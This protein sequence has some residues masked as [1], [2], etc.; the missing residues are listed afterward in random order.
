[1]RAKFFSYLQQNIWLNADGTLL[2]LRKEKLSESRPSYSALQ[3]GLKLL[4]AALGT[5]SSKALGTTRLRYPP[6]RMRT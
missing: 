1:V 5:S 2:Q 6:P 3:F 4:N